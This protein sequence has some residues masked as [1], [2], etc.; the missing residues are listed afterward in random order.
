LSGE[1]A[2]PEDSEAK[3]DTGQLKFGRRRRRREETREGMEALERYS[4]ELVV[5]LRRVNCILNDH[6]LGVKV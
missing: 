6:A 3:N 5:E 4:W 1:G 2:T